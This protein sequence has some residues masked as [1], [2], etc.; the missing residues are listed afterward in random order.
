MTTARDHPKH[1][2]DAQEGYTQQNTWLAAENGVG[3]PSG[4]NREKS[5]EE[6]PQLPGSGDDDEAQ[7]NSDLVNLWTQRLQVLTVVTAFLAA[8]DGQLFTLSVLNTQIGLPVGSTSREIV[9]SCLASALIFHICATLLSYVASFALI[10]YR[11]LEAVTEDGAKVET[12]PYP[13][14]PHPR[15]VVAEPVHPLQ[16]FVNAIQPVESLRFFAV[17]R[18]ARFNQPAPLALLTR[19]FLTTLILSALGFI[20]AVSGI[21][22][23]AWVGLPMVV[24]ITSTV[25]VGVGV[26]AA[27]W[28][29]AL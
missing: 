8:M 17:F 2:G 16:L 24:G 3:G 11:V 20:S 18:S 26:S 19:C 12:A 6:A 22:A 1:P 29:I 25:C 10:R 13:A 15:K 27:V 4:T 21:L 23:Y 9:Y 28:A 14:Q 7:I 5:T